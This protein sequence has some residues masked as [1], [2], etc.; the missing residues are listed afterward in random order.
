M[1]DLLRAVQGKYD[2]LG[3]PSLSHFTTLQK[4]FKS[5]RVVGAP[6]ALSPPPA[7]GVAAPVASRFS[8]VCLP[9]RALYVVLRIAYA[10]RLVSRGHLVPIMLI[11]CLVFCCSGP[12]SPMTPPSSSSAHA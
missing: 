11:R 9:L 7:P 6:H 2:T 4:K 8:R 3:Y 10:R 12:A 5:L 1:P